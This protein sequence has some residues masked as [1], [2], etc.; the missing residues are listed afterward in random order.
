MVVYP[1]NPP[2][3]VAAFH[4][5]QFESWLFALLIQ[6]PASGLGKQERMFQQHLELLH[7]TWENHKKLLALGCSSSGQCDQ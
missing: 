3:A 1:V 5:G 7:P 4:M 2:P 6:L